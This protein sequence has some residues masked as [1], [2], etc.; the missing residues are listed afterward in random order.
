MAVDWSWRA[1]AP[2]HL[3]LYERVSRSLNMGPWTAHQR[4]RG[5]V[6]SGPWQPNRRSSS[7]SSPA[8]RASACSRS[9]RPGQAGRALRRQLPHHRLRAVELRQ[10][11]VPEDRGAHAVQEPQPRPPH[12]PDVAVLDP[13]RQLRDAGAGPDAAGAV[14]VLGLGR[15]HL[16]EPQPHQRRAARRRVRV[17]RRP[18]LPHGPAPDGGAPPRVGRRRHRGRH[19]G[20]RRTRPRRSASSSRT[21]PARSSP[22]TRSRPTPP[23]MPGDPTRC[24]ASMGNYVFTTKTL[25]DIVTPTGEDNQITDLGGHVIPALTAQGVAHVYDFSTNVVP[26]QDERE[27]GYWRDVGTLDC[28][29][30]RQHGPAGAGAGRSTSTTTRGRCTPATTRARRPRCRA[31]G[32]ASPRSSTAACCARAR[33]CRA[34][35]SSGRSSG[36]GCTS[37]TTPTSSTRSS[38]PA[39]TIGPGARLQ[40]GHRRQERRRAGRAC[41]SAS[42]ATVDESRFTVSDNGITVIDKDR[43]LDV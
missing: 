37:T 41:A 10:R 26:G 34:P 22:S 33:S 32:A 8:A 39:C 30:R 31:A 40:P 21:P 12:Q 24:L 19:P 35:T 11:P 4:A 3:D 2:R 13:A 28:V 1:P 25:V 6:R 5:W 15:R 23:S 36:P 20:A 18:H 38:S 14:L 42:T 17:R 43:N 27:K 7:S 9:R 16:P 29:L